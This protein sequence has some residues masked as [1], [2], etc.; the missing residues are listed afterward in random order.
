[1]NLG[2]G[3]FKENTSYALFFWCDFL[4]R[5]CHVWMLVAINDDISVG[6]NLGQGNGNMVVQA[7]LRD[8]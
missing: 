7:F 4:R 8:L 1:M 5:F 2:Q 6:K 3:N